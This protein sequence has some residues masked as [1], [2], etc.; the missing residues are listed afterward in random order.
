MSRN[1]II[2]LFAC[3]VLLQIAVP[4]S[5]IVQR[6]SILKTGT[7]FRFKTAPVDPY[8][9]FRG[10]FVALRVAGGDNIP[11][12]EGLDLKYGQKVYAQ[13]GLDDKG[14]AKVSQITLQKPQGSAYMTATV[15]VFSPLTKEVV[16]HLPI[17]RYYM[18]ESAA[19]RAERVYREH[20]RR[21][22]RQDA[23]V[24]VRVKDGE[25]V[26]EELYIG[27]ERIEDVLKQ[28]KEKK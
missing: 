10:R 4:V 6:E 20:S 23:Y 7:Q 2:G 21:G 3:L 16:L 13:I 25:A 17:D 9:A 11:R 24:D 14:F 26:I 8:D 18:E 19:P 22:V 28:A 12:P 1:L 15:N 5:M 27:G